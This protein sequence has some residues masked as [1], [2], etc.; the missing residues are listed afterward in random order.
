MQ[1]CE[2]GK[3]GHRTGHD[4][5]KAYLQEEHARHHECG[6]TITLNPHAFK[7]HPSK[8]HDVFFTAKYVRDLQGQ[9]G[10]SALFMKDDN[11]YQPT[12]LT[13]E[14]CDPP[15]E[16][17]S[18]DFTLGFNPLSPVYCVEQHDN[19]RSEPSGPEE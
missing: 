2:K 19:T 5:V 18:V 3:E 7:R 16:D 11:T 17:D 9:M 14:W 6:A 4:T 10:G 13:H 15:L 12:P 1:T 8:G